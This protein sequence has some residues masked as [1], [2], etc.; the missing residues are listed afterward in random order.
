[1][2]LASEGNL[3]WQ[4]QGEGNEILELAN[5]EFGI[6]WKLESEETYVIYP[7]MTVQMRRCR[8]PLRD[9]SRSVL[10]R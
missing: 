2:R 10:N 1:M 8:V 4:V 7:Q 3:H 6:W 5:H 9:V